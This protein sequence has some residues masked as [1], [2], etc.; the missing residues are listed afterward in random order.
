MHGGIR[1]SAHLFELP[2]VG[3]GGDGVGQL[4][5]QALHDSVHVLPLRL[6]IN[7]GSLQTTTTQ[8][9]LLQ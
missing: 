5:F 6:K 9:H 4:V 1:P 7:I 3:H 2:A 8:V